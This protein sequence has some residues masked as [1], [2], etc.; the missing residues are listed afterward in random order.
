MCEWLLLYPQQ[1]SLHSPHM[2]KIC[3]MIE[4]INIYFMCN[5]SFQV[6]NF[7]PQQ[8]AWIVERFGRYLKTLEP[9]SIYHNI[10]LS[11]AISQGTERFNTIC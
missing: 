11:I 7:V 3:Q 4:V 2:F 8:Q 1:M 5:L 9:V 6:I 10:N